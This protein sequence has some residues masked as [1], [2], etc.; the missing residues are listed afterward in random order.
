MEANDVSTDFLIDE[1][2]KIEDIFKIRW[3]REEKNA[4]VVREKKIFR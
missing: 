3:S 1:L 2:K 4:E